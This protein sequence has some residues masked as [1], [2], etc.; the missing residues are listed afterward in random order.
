MSDRVAIEQSIAE[1]EAGQ[2][3]PLDEVVASL[4]AKRASH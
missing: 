4:R 3:V 2:T 1:I